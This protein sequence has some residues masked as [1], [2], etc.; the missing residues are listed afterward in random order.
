MIASTN[1]HPGRS[2]FKQPYSLVKDQGIQGFNEGEI[3]RKAVWIE[4][5]RTDV[6]RSTGK[7][8]RRKIKRY[9]ENLFHEFIAHEAKSKK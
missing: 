4:N 9:Y 2:N 7:T 5:R 8:K 3:D 1:E 6:A